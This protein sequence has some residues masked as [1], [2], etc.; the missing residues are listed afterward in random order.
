M[1]IHPRLRSVQPQCTQRAVFVVRGD[2]GDG[3]VEGHRVEDLVLEH[4]QVVQA[5]GV[6][7]AVTCNSTYTL[8]SLYPYAYSVAFSGSVSE[9]SGS[10]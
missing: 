3:A 2:E 4:V 10:P 6:S 5:V 8:S 9:C 7:V 1:Y